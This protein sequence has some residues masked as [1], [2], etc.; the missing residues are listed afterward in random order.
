MKDTNLINNEKLALNIENMVFEGIR[1][2]IP[3]ALS[4]YTNPL[5]EIVRQVIEDNEKDLYDIFSKNLKSI[6]S[7]K[8][9]NC[10]ISDEFK[11]KVA[12]NLV[13]SLEGSVEKS[14]NIYR[15]NP[16]LKAEMIIAIQ[17]IIDDNK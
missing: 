6:I 13:G 14:V 3:A 16:T 8:K 11:R 17:N 9:F 12:K 10:M 2:A 1:E 4:S 15:Q 7:D 5:H